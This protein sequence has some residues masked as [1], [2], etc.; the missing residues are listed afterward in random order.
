[1]L[2]SISKMEDGSA[3]PYPVSEFDLSQIQKWEKV[4]TSPEAREILPYFRQLA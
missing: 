2:Q 1:M 3:P 4:G